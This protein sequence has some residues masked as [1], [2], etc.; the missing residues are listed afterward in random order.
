VRFEEL[1]FSSQLQNALFHFR[2]KQLKII[3]LVGARPQFVKAA[4]ISLALKNHPHV[5]EYLVHSGQHY[6]YRLSEVFFTELNLPVPF[7]HLEVGAGEASAQTEKIMQGLARV[8]AQV[9]PDILVVYG[10]TTTTLAGTLAAEKAGIAV[11]HIEAGLRS[12]NAQMPEEYNRVET[13]KRSKWLFA[14]TTLAIQNLKNEGIVDGKLAQ[15]VLVGDVMLDS[16]RVFSAKSKKPQA[17]ADINLKKPLLLLTLHRNFNADHAEKLSRILHQLATVAIDFDVI[18]PVHPRT[19]KNLTHFDCP[20]NLH[21]LAPVSYFEMLWLEQNAA[22]IATDSGGVQKEA[23]YFKKPLIVLREETEWQELV[24]AQVAFLV[25][26][27]FE[28]MQNAINQCKNFIY[29]NTPHF[30]GDAYAA[31]KI[32]EILAAQ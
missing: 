9:Q 31:N 20:L 21:M 6:D 5:Q 18:F 30:Y 22:I 11:A 7:A 4:A 27:D 25:G 8:F 3:N 12:H 28:R 15:V 13:D 2:L 19:Q 17:L 1:R 16:T 32:C 23:F 10:D 26:D 29:P 14:P 24:D